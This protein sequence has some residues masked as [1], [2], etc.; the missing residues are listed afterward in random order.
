MDYILANPNGKLILFVPDLERY[1]RTNGF[2]VALEE[3]TP[4]IAHS[5]TELVA[6][7]H[8][9]AGHGFDDYRDKYLALCDGQ[10]TDRLLKHLNISSG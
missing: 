8:S 9:D 3:V 7:I 5:A 4:L 1:E 10:A 6:A 2:Y